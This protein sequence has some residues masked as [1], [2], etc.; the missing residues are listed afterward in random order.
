MVRVDGGR[1]THFVY[2]GR[3]L[4]PKTRAT[5]LESRAF[6]GRCLAGR[7]EL[8]AVFQRERVDRRRSLQSSLF[9]AEPAADLIHEELIERRLPRL[10]FTLKRVRAKQC[11]EIDG[12]SR[13]ML[14]KPLDLTPRRGG[15]DEE[16][17]EDDRNDRQDGG[18]DDAS[19]A[20]ATLV[21]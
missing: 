16:S 10:S 14:S 21:E 3:I 12:R 9:V 1:S 18:S 7:G 20:P 8:Y 15:D 2:P 6:F 5:L 13:M 11:V 17:D 4:D 19:D